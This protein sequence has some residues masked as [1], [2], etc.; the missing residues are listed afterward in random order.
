[1]H[2]QLGDQRIVIGRDLVAG[3]NMRIDANARPDGQSQMGDDTR[4]WQE[5]F[6]ILGVD[7]AFEGM[8]FA[9]YI[10]LVEIQN[11][12]LSC[13]YLRLDDIDA[14]RHFGDGMLD[15]KSRVHLD[16]IESAVLIKE[17]EGSNAPVADLEAGLHASQADRLDDVGRDPRRLSAS[18][19][20]F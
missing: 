18:S 5:G 14:A 13:P 8:A 12:T 2:D 9:C 19:T 3:M 16:E 7:T 6:R 1:M 15:L 20:T 17:F 4:R 11:V 10:A